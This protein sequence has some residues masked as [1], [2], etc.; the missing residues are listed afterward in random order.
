MFGIDA[1]SSS[2]AEYIAPEDQLYLGIVKVTSL[3]D[4]IDCKPALKFLIV[5]GVSVGVGTVS[6]SFHCSDLPIPR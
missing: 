3:A 2:Y 5:L 1:K 6:V 4:F